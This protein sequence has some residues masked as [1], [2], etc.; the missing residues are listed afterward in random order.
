MTVLL[1][2]F[3][4]PNFVSRC[5]QPSHAFKSLGQIGPCSG[6]RAPVVNIAAFF[7]ARIIVHFPDLLLQTTLYI[8]IYYV[9]A[10][11]PVGF[12]YY[13][14]PGILITFAGSGWATSSLR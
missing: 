5:S 12:F 1:R 2:T 3:K 14:L 6:A 11:P 4:L 13:F 10:M 9:I 7:Y 8:C